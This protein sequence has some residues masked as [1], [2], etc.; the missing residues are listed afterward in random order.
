MVLAFFDWPALQRELLP[1]GLGLAELW[2]VHS[3]AASRDCISGL[4]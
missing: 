4:P 2:D 3:M 1:L